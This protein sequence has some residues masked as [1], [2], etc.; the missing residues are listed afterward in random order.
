[1][2]AKTGD[3]VV[4]EFEAGRHTIRASVS[5]FRGTTRVDLREWFEPEPG[6]ELIPTKKGINLPAE[7]LEELAEAVAALATA[8][9]GKA[10]A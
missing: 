6:A 10:A 2:S 3:L 8:V 5:S 9:K 7:Y 4:A 1:M